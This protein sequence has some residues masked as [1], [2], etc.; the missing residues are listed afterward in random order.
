MKIRRAAAVLGLATAMVGGTALAASAITGGQADGEGH[1]NV[2]MIAFYDATGRY[3]CS[4]TLVSPTVLVTAAHCT[5]GTLGKTAVTFD[6]VVAE[7]PPSPLPVA[8]DPAAG[9]TSAELTA[10]GYHSGTA[11]THPQ[12]SNFTDLKNWNDVGVVVLDTPV[13]DRAPA[14]VAPTGYL[15]QFT[16]NVLNQTLFTSVGYGTEVRQAE[17]GSRKPTPQSYPIIRRVTEEKGQKLTPQILQVNGNG[18]DPFGGGGT[19]F[20]DSGGPSF[21]GGYQVTVTSYGYTSNCRYLGGLQRIDVP[22]VQ[23]WLAGFGVGHG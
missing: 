12:Y 1:P 17:S 22:V 19:C 20:G 5:D 8:A 23:D 16:P 7:Q 6:S 11:H 13:T 4:A 2:A 15:D 9:Y 10:A 18:N 3:R 14:T 21:K